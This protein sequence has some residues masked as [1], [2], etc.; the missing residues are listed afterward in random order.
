ML[1]SSPSKKQRNEKISLNN[2][3]LEVDYKM[4]INILIE[5]LYITVQ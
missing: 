5:H 3:I 4:I 2:D 1:L